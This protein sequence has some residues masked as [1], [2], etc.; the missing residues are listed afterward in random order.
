MAKI[1]SLRAAVGATWD[2]C[3]LEKGHPVVAWRAFETLNGRV[4]AFRERSERP[5]AIKA[6]STTGDAAPDG[7]EL[8]EIVYRWSHRI[9]VTDIGSAFSF[10]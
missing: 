6:A 3:R 10:F 1:S 8:S 2:L 9:A 5:I 7:D 4:Y